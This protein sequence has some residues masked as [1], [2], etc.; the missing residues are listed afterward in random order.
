MVE[1]RAGPPRRDP[2]CWSARAVLILKEPRSVI[3]LC[4]L[5]EVGAMVLTASH[6]R[7]ATLSS[8]WVAP[9]AA[10]VVAVALAIGSGFGS[11]GEPRWPT[12]DEVR[13]LKERYQAEHDAL[14]KSGA[15]TR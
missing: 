8:H 7:I 4:P 14:V 3:R 2:P 11:A 9:A 15:A 5:Q 1:G 13:Q 12:A 6:P 10:G